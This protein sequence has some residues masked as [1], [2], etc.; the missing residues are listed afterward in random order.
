MAVSKILL[1][2]RTRLA[3]DFKDRAEE[4]KA[5][6]TARL[7]YLY[8]EAAEQWERSC[9]DR[10]CQTIRGG[11]VHF[12]DDGPAPLPDEVTTAREGQSGNP[13]LLNQARGA[14]ADI[15]AIWGLDAPKKQD[16]TTGG[17]PFKVYG[18]FDPEQV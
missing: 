6:Q 18:G 16:L 1:R 15:R 14:L 5:E 7:E 9:E 8:S 4:I 17:Q 2:V 12:G 13:A 10:V 3:A 11:R